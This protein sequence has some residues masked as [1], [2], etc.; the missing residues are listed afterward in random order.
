MRADLLG[1]LAASAALL[2]SAAT[3]AGAGAAVGAA[4]NA[5]PAAAATGAYGGSASGNLVGLTAVTIPGSFQAANV[6]LAPSTAQ[7]SSASQITAAPGKQSYARADNLDAQLISGSIPLNNLVVEADQSAAPDNPTGVS[8]ILASVPADP[9]ADATVTTAYANAR[10]AGADACVPVGTD[11]ADGTSTAATANV[12]TG[13]PLGSAA[14]SVVNNAGGPVT[15][16]ST[17]RMVS[18]PGQATTAEG[19]TSTQLDQL[20]GIVLFK[21][22]ANEL[23]INVLAPP[24]ITATATGFPGGASVS[25]TEPILQVIQGGKVIGTLDAKTGNTTLTIPALATLSLGTLAQ[26]VAAD[27]TSASGSASLLSVQV[28]IA[29]LPLNVATIVVAGGSAA[30]SVPAGGVYC[31]PTTNPLSESHKDASA[32]VVGPGQQFTYTISVPNRGTCVLDPV[33]VSDT[34][35]GPAGTTVVSSTPT[36]TASSSNPLQL[37]WS[38]G[39]LQPDQTTNITVVIQAPSTLTTGESFSDNGTVSGLCEGAPAGTPPFTAPISFQGPTGFSPTVSGCHLDDSNKATDHLQ[40]MPGETFN[41]YVHV[42]NDGSSPC[43]NVTVTDPLGSGVTFVSASNGGTESGG[44]ATWTIGTIA[45]GASVTLTLEVRANPSDPAGT[46]LPNRATIVST[47]E[48]NGIPVSTAGPTVSTVSQLAPANPA[49]P[50]TPAPATSAPTTPSVGGST[51]PE[52]SSG[53]TL[54]MTGGQPYAPY[55]LG[56]LIVGVAIRGFRRRARQ[57]A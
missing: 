36:G 16:S 53:G 45:P 12:L 22:S 44:A 11:I 35:T 42:L 41:Y 57:H 49:T 56:L 33:T 4:V 39:P 38:I 26:T 54:P 50:S 48:P 30:A 13:T 34:I 47:E 24:Q 28:G 21:G 52:P 6:A 1:R 10:W 32:S 37:T 7:V 43:T 20:T 55:G 29:P 25:Y 8:K 9:L 17:V 23:T 51:G 2:V 31:P 46:T 19:V 27:G 14:V 5:N 15:S 18:I 3:V 40:V